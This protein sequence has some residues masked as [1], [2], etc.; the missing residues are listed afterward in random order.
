MD[1]LAMIRSYRDGVVVFCLLLLLVPALVLIYD[2]AMYIGLWY[3]LALAA[4][5]CRRPGFLSGAG[6]ALAVEFLLLLQYNW[7]ADVDEM[8]ALLH[9]IGLPGI[10]LGMVYAYRRFERVLPQSSWAVMWGGCLSVLV[11]FTAMQV[12]FYLFSWA[13]GH[14]MML[15]VGLLN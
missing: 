6:I 10:L 9:L 7:R 5:L 2:D 4:W 14:F 1:R 15:I 11:G 3:Y 12:F 13:Y 8:V